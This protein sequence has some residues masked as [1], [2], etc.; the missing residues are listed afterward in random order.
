MKWQV[1]LLVL[2]VCLGGMAQ[3]Q[4]WRVDPTAPGSQD[5]LTWATAFHTIQPAI[6]AAYA[7]GGGQVWVAGGTIGSPRVYNEPRTEAWGGPA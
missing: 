5:G 2:V 4:V 7:A 1:P 3:A 6:D